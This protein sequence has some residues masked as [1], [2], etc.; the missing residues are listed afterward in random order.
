MQTR[1]RG[2]VVETSISGTAL[3]S[4]IASVDDYLMNLSIAED[5]CSCVSQGTLNRPGDERELTGE[6]NTIL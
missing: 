2:S 4:I 5:A 6:E 1:A 3:R